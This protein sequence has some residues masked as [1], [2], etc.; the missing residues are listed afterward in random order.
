LLKYLILSGVGVGAFFSVI[1]TNKLALPQEPQSLGI[2]KQ[3]YLESQNIT[4]YEYQKKETDLSVILNCLIKCESGGNPLAVGKAG[5][6]GILQFMPK[7]YKSYCVD[8]YGFSEDIW[9]VD[10]QKNCA[11]KMLSEN[12]NKNIKHWTTAKLC[13]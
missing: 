4:D 1:A 6:R 9:N 3:D 5:E 8:K 7:T 11:F 12:F 2:N 10:N 13:L